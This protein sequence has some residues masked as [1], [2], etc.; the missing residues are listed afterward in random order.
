[1]ALDGMQTGRRT[2]CAWIT[3]PN[4]IGSVRSCVV[5]NSISLG[6]R[7]RYLKEIFVAVQVELQGDLG[8][9]DRARR[10]HL[11][12]ARDLAELQLQR[13]CHRRSHGLRV[14]TRQ[15]GRDR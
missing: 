10:C 14:R 12:E 7:F 3:V 8:V 1:M 11:S 9:A 5:S 6:K 13:R 15:L 4:A 2:S